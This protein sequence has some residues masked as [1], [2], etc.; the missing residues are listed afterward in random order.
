MRDQATDLLDD[1]VVGQGDAVFVHFP[2]AAL[3]HQLLDLQQGSREREAQKGAR[4]LLLQKLRQLE[5]ARALGK[6][7]AVQAVQQYNK[8]R[9]DSSSYQRQWGMQRLPLADGTSTETMLCSFAQA[10]RNRS[11]TGFWTRNHAKD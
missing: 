1:G 2:V 9:G 11:G 8:V 7:R 4:Q 5:M 10:M 6:E 3:V